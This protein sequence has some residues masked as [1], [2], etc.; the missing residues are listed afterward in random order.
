M[1][2]IYATHDIVL[3]LCRCDIMDVY[4]F[5]SLQ[6][7]TGLWGNLRGNCRYVDCLC[8]S[9]YYLARSHLALWPTSDFHPKVI[10]KIYNMKT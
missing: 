9:Q 6:Y 4:I 2:K 7:D 8:G 3:N 1:P 10:S 5:F